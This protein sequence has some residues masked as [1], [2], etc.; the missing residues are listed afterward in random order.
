MDARIE[1]A[2]DGSRITIVGISCWIDARVKPAHDESHC[3]KDRRPS[4]E[5][6]QDKRRFPA[7]ASPFRHRAVAALVA[8][9]A[10]F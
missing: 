5:S 7:S 3:L 8:R 1:P 6:N 4:L 2:H 9:S 10:E